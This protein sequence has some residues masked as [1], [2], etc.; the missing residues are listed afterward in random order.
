MSGQ[1]GE[2]NTLGPMQPAAAWERI[3]P[4]CVPPPGSEPVALADA[5]GRVLAADVTAPHDVPRAPN[6]AM[7]GFA[8]RAA[9]GPHD[10]ALVAGESRAGAPFMRGFAPGM[11]IRIATGG[12]VPD[13]FDSVVRVEDAQVGE[14]GRVTLPRVDEG[15]EVRAA[16][17]DLAA[18]AVV[19][20]RGVRLAPHHLAA[21]AG[22]GVAHVRCHRRPIVS[23]VITGDEVIPPGQIPGPG[24]VTD[25]H[26]FG[27]PPM[28]RAT[29]AR[30][31]EVVHVP[32]DPRALEAA[33]DALAPADVVLVTG[34][35]SVGEHDHTRAGIELRGAAL[36]VPRLL[37]RPGQPTAVWAGLAGGAGPRLWFGLPGNP[38]AAFVIARLLL[39][40]ALEALGG[41]DPQALTG[42]RLAITEPAGGDPRRWMAAR[43][44]YSGDGEVNLLP[45]QG[46]HMVSG[47]AIGECLALV[48]PSPHEHPAGTLV[49]TLAFVGADS[50]GVHT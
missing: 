37:L 43:A 41:A 4:H 10:D 32:D 8:V 21:I 26:G 48:P 40:P 29:G 38:A 36:I 11:V 45:R 35:L 20:Q 28:I 17:E 9:D 19:V 13:G 42:R 3:A 25:V 27:L 15:R 50:Y 6:S 1:G 31:G 22:A 46:S 5:A 2:G 7:D 23:L 24:Q 47:L 33:L 49:E 30:I 16:G 44:R 39:V 14:D 34:G 18:G 12:V